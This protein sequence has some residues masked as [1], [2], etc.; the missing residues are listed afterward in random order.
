MNLDIKN[1]SDSSLQ[2]PVKSETEQ[3][4]MSMYSKSI[5][6]KST[7]YKSNYNNKIEKKG[8]QPILPKH[9]IN[10][11]NPIISKSK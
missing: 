9:L 5:G 8:P 6:N 1:N 4:N 2:M 10:T 11:A 3:N 7:S